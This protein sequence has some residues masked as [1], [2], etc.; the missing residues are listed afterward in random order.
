[1]LRSCTRAECSSPTYVTAV[2][3]IARS[4]STPTSTSQYYADLFAGRLG[5]EVMR[6]FKVYP[7]IFGVTIN[8]DAA[9]LSLRLFDHPWS[10]VFRRTIADGA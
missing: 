7:S 5:F 8:D 4:C 2:T 10:F 6:T 3:T 9:K 1:M